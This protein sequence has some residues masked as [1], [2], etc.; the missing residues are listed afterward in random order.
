M[1]IY[2]YFSTSPVINA[3]GRKFHYNL[4]FFSA[5]RPHKR[6]EDVCS[7]EFIAAYQVQWAPACLMAL[8]VSSIKDSCWKEI[9]LGKCN[10]YR[11]ALHVN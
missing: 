11:G 9:D 2:G 3:A 6:G 5:I 1:L 7:M 10:H 8:V 4:V